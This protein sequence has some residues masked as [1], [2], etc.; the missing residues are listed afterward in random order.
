LGLNYNQFI[1][2][3]KKQN[4]VLDRKILA[5]LAEKHPQIFREIIAMVK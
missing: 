4:I 3:L 5:E 1:S 2:K